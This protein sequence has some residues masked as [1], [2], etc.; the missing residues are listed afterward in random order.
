MPML[1]REN[2]ERYSRP[3]LLGVL[4]HPR[5]YSPFPQQEVSTAKMNA[6]HFEES[7]ARTR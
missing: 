4:V 2:P 3:G 5:T 1:R 7:H 6:I